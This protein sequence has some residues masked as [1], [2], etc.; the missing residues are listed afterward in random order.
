M[1]KEDSP[2]EIYRQRYAK[3]QGELRIGLGEAQAVQR[4]FEEGCQVERTPQ[5]RVERMGEEYQELLDALVK[6]NQCDTPESRFELAM[7]AT[8]LIVL[9]LSVIDA[10]GHNAEELFLTKMQRNFLKYNPALVDLLVQSGK[11]PAEAMGTLKHNWKVIY[12]SE[13]I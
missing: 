7:E 10:T 6:V 1:S 9:A 12:E 4:I 13:E 11:T 3:M 2:L 8:D 5:A